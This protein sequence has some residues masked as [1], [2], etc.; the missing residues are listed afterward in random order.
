MNAGTFTSVFA[1]PEFFS[2]LDDPRLV[3]EGNRILLFYGGLDP[4]S[5]E[6]TY[7]G[8]CVRIKARIHQKFGGGDFETS[9][10]TQEVPVSVEYDMGVVVLHLE[11]KASHVLK[12]SGK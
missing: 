8:I 9:F 12:V 10:Y 5:I 1:R 6:V 11:N 7:E 3:R 2:H 4:A